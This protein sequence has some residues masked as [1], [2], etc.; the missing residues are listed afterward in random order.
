MIRCICLDRWV[1]VLETLSL[2]LQSGGTM[3]LRNTSASARDICDDRA[4]VPHPVGF[5]RGRYVMGRIHAGVRH[6]A[7]TLRL[8]G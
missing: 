3:G 4:T 1:D 5:I 7:S 8:P 2:L 6:I